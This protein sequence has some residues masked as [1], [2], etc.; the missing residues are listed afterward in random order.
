MDVTRGLLHS[1]EKPVS[2]PA[3]TIPSIKHVEGKYPIPRLRC[4][5]QALEKTTPLLISLGEMGGEGGA[6]FGRRDMFQGHTPEKRETWIQVS[7]QN[8]FNL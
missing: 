6:A 1:F 3:I 7:V 8:L 5:T 2:N 4:L